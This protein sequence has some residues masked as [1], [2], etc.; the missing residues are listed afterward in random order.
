MTCYQCRLWMVHQV[1]HVQFFWQPRCLADKNS[2]RNPMIKS[3]AVSYPMNAAEC[4]SLVTL[5]T[6]CQTQGGSTGGDWVQRPTSRLSVALAWGPNFEFLQQSK[7]YLSAA[8]Q[9][10][11]PDENL[12]TAIDTNLFDY[13]WVQF[14]NNPGCQYADGSAANLLTAWN[15]WV[16]VPA[17]QVFLGLPAAP[18]AAGS[19]YV[20]PGVVVSEILP[21]IKT[22]PKYGG[23][24]LWSKFY[25]NGF[26]ADIKPSV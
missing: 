10:V 3:F 9:C 22:S 23:V 11:F 7:V 20:E 5:G 19:G 15:Q 1:I 17:R 14:Y 18:E 25:D 6:G 12:K 2:V 24:M 4:W 16:S 21:T 26:S 13:V 8:P